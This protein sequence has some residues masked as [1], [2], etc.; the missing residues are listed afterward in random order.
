MIYYSNLLKFSKNLNYFRSLLTILIIKMIN[1]D[2]K[3]FSLNIF[4]Q[5]LKT[6]ILLTK[7]KKYIYNNCFQINWRPL[8][9]TKMFPPKKILKNYNIFMPKTSNHFKKTY[10]AKIYKAFLLNFIRSHQTKV[11]HI[12]KPWLDLILNILVICLMFFSSQL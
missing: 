2:I 1:L 5:I 10:H 12:N 7:K 9:G 11:V 3:G 4:L 8:C 6:N